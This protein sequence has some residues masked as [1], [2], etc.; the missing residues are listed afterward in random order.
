MTPR[1]AFTKR[2]KK[3]GQTLDWPRKKFT[4]INKIKN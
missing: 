4:Q 3:N 2:L 1:V